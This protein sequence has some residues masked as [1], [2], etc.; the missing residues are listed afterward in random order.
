MQ[1]SL[2]F[3][4]TGKDEGNAGIYKSGEILRA[5]RRGGIWI[6]PQECSLGLSVALHPCPLYLAHQENAPVSQSDQGMVGKKDGKTEKG[7]G[8]AGRRKAL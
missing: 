6:L 7:F 4:F 1:R 8:T 2:F 5:V 3:Y